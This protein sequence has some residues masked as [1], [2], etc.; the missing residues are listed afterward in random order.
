MW[1]L[2]DEQRELRD[3]I[4][5]FSLATVRPRM[6]EVDETC[7]YPFELHRAMGQEGLLGLA[8]PEAYGGRG[9]N[10]VSFNAYVE[11]LAKVS[12]T[13]SL[14]AAYVKLTACRSCWPAA[15]SKSAAS[16]PGWPQASN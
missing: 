12:A 11:E 6:R 1:R 7:D 8:V 13:A 16:C 9:A 3:R 5:E 10:S 4:R 15:R 2:T 14:I